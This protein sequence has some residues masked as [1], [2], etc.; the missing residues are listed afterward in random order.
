MP[1]FKAFYNNGNIK[2]NITED[3]V[4][5]NMYE[6]YNYKSNGVD[7]LKHKST[8]D[9]KNWTKKDYIKLARKNPIKFLKKTSGDFFIE[10]DGY[11]LGLNEE[12]LK[13]IENE[14]FKQHFKDIIE[15]KT[16]NYYKERYENDK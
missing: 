9:Y 8:K 11:L 6:Y 14:N 7:M 15:Y 1:I 2:M 13:Y 12:L 3:D 10:K 16:L 5:R 4:Y